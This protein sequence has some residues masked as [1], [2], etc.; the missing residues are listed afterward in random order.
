MTTMVQLKKSLV[1]GLNGLD[2]VTSWLAVSLQSQSNSDSDSESLLSQL[3]VAVVRSEKLV[4]EAEKNS[5]TLKKMN[6]LL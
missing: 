5:G 3:R 6:V 4:G 1:L 2:A